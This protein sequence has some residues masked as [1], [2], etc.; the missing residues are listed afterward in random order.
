VR[1]AC[2]KKRMVLCYWMLLHVSMTGKEDARN[3]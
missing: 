3:R 2:T 1:D